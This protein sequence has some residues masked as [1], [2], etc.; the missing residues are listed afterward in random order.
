M[1]YVAGEFTAR[2]S[3]GPLLRMIDRVARFLQRE[4]FG[5]VHGGKFLIPVMQR[6]DFSRVL[7]Q[8]EIALPIAVRQLM[9]LHLDFDAFVTGLDHAPTLRLSRPEVESNPR[10]VLIGWIVMGGGVPHPSVLRPKVRRG[11]VRVLT[12]LSALSPNDRAE[13][14]H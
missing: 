5:Q 12:L 10:A 8:S 2:R 13:R 7:D 3:R 11:G 14:V 9:H 1:T 4:F 6:F